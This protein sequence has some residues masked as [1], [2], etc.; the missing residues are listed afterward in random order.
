MCSGL[1]D[2]MCI[3]VFFNCLIFMFPALRDFICTS[4]FFNSMIFMCVLSCV[5]HVHKHLFELHDLDVCQC[6]YSF[7]FFMCGIR[8]VAGSRPE[9]VNDFYQCKI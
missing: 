2:F 7:S 1:R 4:F 9:E 8:K 6:L 3:N 5:N